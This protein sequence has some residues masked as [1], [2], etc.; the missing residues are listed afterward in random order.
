[1]SF[2]NGIITKKIQES[3]EFYTGKLGFTVKFD[4]D[5]NTKENVC[6]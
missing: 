4:A 1:M 3:K 5:T 6:G 2:Y